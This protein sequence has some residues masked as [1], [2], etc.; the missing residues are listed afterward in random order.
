MSGIFLFTLQCYFVAVLG[1]SAIAKLDCL[2]CF[3]NT[4][5]QQ[6]LLPPH[7][8]VPTSR[9]LPAAEWGLALSLAGGFIPQASATMLLLLFLVFL[10]MEVALYRAKSSADCG[11]YGDA[12]HQSVDPSSIVVSTT[13]VSLAVVNFALVLGGARVNSGWLQTVLL[14]TFLAGSVWLFYKLLKRKRYEQT[15]RRDYMSHRMASGV[16]TTAA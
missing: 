11:C 2:S 15:L 12:H 13:L 14:A 10:S 4:L 8:I 6:K 5:K 7:L 1:I 3:A 9:I 16:G